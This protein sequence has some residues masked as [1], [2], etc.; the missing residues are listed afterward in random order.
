MIKVF[1]VIKRIV[2]NEVMFTDGGGVS[3][4]GNDTDGDSDVVMVVVSSLSCTDD[5]RGGDNAT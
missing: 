3:N 1:I 4:D 2:E 5:S